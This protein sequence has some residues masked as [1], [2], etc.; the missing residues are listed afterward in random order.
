MKETYKGCMLIEELDYFMLQRG[1][2]R[3]ETGEWVA[4]TW[5]DALYIRKYKI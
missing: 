5:T 4:D 2:E 1:F 3:V